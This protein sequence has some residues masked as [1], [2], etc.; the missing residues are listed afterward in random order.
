VLEVIG[1]TQQFGNQTTSLGVRQLWHRDVHRPMAQD[2]GENT[3]NP[4]LKRIRP[5]VAPE[6]RRPDELG[7]T[8]EP[9]RERQL[10]IAKNSQSVFDL[11]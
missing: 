4:L 6:G 8:F 3:L 10:L 5:F 2:P 11:V 7:S 1:P 9:F